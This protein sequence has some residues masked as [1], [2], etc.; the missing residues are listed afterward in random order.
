MITLHSTCRWNKRLF[1]NS[2]S[3]VM[4]PLE[5]LWGQVNDALTKSVNEMKSCRHG[6]G[7]ARAGRYFPWLRPMQVDI[8]QSKYSTYV[9]G[10]YQIRK[11]EIDYFVDSHADL[12]AAFTDVYLTGDSEGAMDAALY[13]HPE[14]DKLLKVSIL[15]SWSCEF[16]YFVSCKDNARICRDD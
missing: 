14:L 12:R 16:N 8:F 3:R 10:V 6:F 7:P 15:N 4:A 11:R 9:K 2:S 13:H 5:N 1:F